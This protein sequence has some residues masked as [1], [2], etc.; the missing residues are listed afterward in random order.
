MNSFS[1]IKKKDGFKGQMAI[2]LPKQV[3]KIYKKSQLLSNLYITDIGFYP[4][5][6]FHYRERKSGCIQHILIYCTGGKGWAIIGNKKV[7]IKEGEYL[8]IPKN[9]KHSYGAD[10]QF[11]WSIYW[12]HFNGNT[13]DD[14]IELLLKKC[15]DY[16]GSTSYS[17]NRMALFND[18]YRTLESGYSIEHLYYIN[19]LFASYLG[20]FC[21]L[22]FLNPPHK[23]E[24]DKIDTA[25]EYMQ[26]NIMAIVSVKALASLIHLSASHFSVM[27]KSKTGYPPLEYFNHLKIQRACQYL[28]F[29]DISV[30]ELTHALGLED[31]FY[32]SRLFKKYM[33]ESPIQ[34]RKRKRFN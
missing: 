2:V 13:S 17:E 20:G 5:A 33:G 15:S 8:V 18:I 14:Y 34:F 25:I 29:T 3:L 1:N 27:F 32:F 16:I 6:E 26:Q 21:F 9:L 30:K 10:E 24:K 22:Q 12:A 7:F 11:P 19:I 28:E 31:P 4:K 23:K